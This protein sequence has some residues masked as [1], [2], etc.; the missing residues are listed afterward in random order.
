MNRY[1]VT[2][3]AR[4]KDDLRKLQKHGF[5][6]FAQTAR[7]DAKKKDF[8]FSIEGLL[9]TGEIETLIKEGYRVLVE[10]TMEARTQAALGTLEF[11]DWLANQQ[12]NIALDSAVRK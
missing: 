3:Y 6:L 11:D 9:A 12:R 5:D 8:G 7:Q 1:F 4:S 2:V 10:D